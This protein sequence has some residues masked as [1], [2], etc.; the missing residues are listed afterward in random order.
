[1]TLADTMN[2]PKNGDAFMLIIEVLFI[3]MAAVLLSGHGSFLIA[4]YNTKTPEEKAKYD[5]KKLC[6]IVGTGMLVIGVLI[7]VS[8][9]FRYQL[10]GW[11]SNVILAVILTDVAA[12]LILMNT[13]GKKKEQSDHT[14]T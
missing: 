3:V 4:G 8:D 13:V 7:I 2:L 12:M 14:E 1:M 5:E 10:P 11:F 6:R 9:K